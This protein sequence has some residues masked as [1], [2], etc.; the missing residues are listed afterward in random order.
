MVVSM[1]HGATSFFSVKLILYWLLISSNLKLMN[2]ELSLLDYV[3]VNHDCLHR[4]MKIQVVKFLIIF[5]I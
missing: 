5:L 3:I 2:S 1:Q 4:F